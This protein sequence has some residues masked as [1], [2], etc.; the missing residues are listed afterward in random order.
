MLWNKSL[1]N[2]R[3]NFQKYSSDLGF[4]LSE[5]QPRQSQRQIVSTEWTFNSI[6]SVNVCKFQPIKNVIRTELKYQLE[7]HPFTRKIS[8]SSN[9]AILLSFWR[10]RTCFLLSPQ[11]WGNFSAPNIKFE[12]EWISF[13][14]PQSNLCVKSP[15]LENF[16][17]SLFDILF[18]SSIL[19]YKFQ[20]SWNYIWIEFINVDSFGR[21]SNVNIIFQI[22]QTN[23]ANF[24]FLLRNQDI[25]IWIKFWNSMWW[26]W[27]EFVLF[28]SSVTTNALSGRVQRNLNSLLHCSL[29]EKCWKVFNTV[30]LLAQNQRFSFINYCGLNHFQKFFFLWFN[31]THQLVPFLVK[32]MAWT[33]WFIYG[34]SLSTSVSCLVP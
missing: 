27:F 10:I 17:R 32:I 11:N 16:Y 3:N 34:Q 15:P 29:C 25:M 23:C 5:D 20:N 31:H 18:S 7:S 30:T 21:N 2:V 22:F 13:L 19:T 33:F 6:D 4:G 28:L 24:R 9:F 26:K 14:D 1:F 8:T 12:S